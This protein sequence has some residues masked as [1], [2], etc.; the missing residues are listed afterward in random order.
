MNS[1]TIDINSPTNQYVNIFL[2]YFGYK[3][4]TFT[5]L[6]GSQYNSASFAIH[7]KEDTIGTATNNKMKYE[8]KSHNDK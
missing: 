7:K 8:E 2:F 3:N 4:R 5:H 1:W 6:F